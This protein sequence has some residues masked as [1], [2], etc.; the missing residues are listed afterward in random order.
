VGTAG[1]HQE[2]FRTLHHQCLLL[3]SSSHLTS[4]PN[5]GNDL[6]GT[7]YLYGLSHTDPDSL[8]EIFWDRGAKVDYGRIV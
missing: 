7:L 4:R 5:A 2:P 1:D 3:D 6:R 8:F